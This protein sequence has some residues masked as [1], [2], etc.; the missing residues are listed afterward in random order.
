MRIYKYTVNEKYNRKKIFQFLKE[1]EEYS[2]QIIKRLKT[3]ENGILLNDKPAKTID[4]IQNGDVITVKLVDETNTAL[5]SLKKAEVVFEDLDYVIFNKPKDMPI[6]QSFMHFNDTLANV[7][8]KYYTDKNENFIFRPINRIDRNTSGLV[9]IAKNPHSANMVK[10]TV[11]KK[12]FAVIK[13]GLT[14]ENG[15]ID[16]PIAREDDSIITRKVDESVD[17]AITNYKTI[18]T[19]NGFSLLEVQMETGR[20]HQ[21]RVHLSHKGYPLI[22]DDL[23]GGDC[24]LLQQHALHCGEI[25]F[26]HFI[27]NEDVVFSADIGLEVMEL[28]T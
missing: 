22:G 9:L 20:T 13:S 19:K 12:Y 10:K 2:T 23:Y 26:F 24:T 3:T 16:L 28:F 6:H 15:T 4:K 8:Q 27:E 5:C 1:N 18:L 14:P 7:F 17:R 25:S 21:I 11:K